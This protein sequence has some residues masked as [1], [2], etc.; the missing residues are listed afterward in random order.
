MQVR[1]LAHS[2][3]LSFI[4][5]TNARTVVRDACQD[6]SRRSPYSSGR[7]LRSDVALRNEGNVNRDP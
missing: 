6:G 2:R 7:F 5:G 1:K 4:I 3:A